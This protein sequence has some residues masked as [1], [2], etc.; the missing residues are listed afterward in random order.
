MKY[1][2]EILQNLLEKIEM[3]KFSKKINFRDHF[4]VFLLIANSGLPFFTNEK[5]ILLASLF[6]TTIFINPALLF[7]NKL[8]NLT[9]IFLLMLLI[10]QWITTGIFDLRTSITLYVRWTYPFIV[11]L[12]VRNRF[13]NIFVNVMYFLTIISLLLFIPSTIS[14]GFENFLLNISKEF[15]QQSSSGFYLYIPNIIIYTIKPE[16]AFADFILFSRNS[17]PFWEP[18]GF[19]SFL[20]VALLFSV[21]I[22]KKFFSKRNMVFIIA[23][24]TTWSTASLAALS[25]LIL[26]YGM[27]ILRKNIYRITLVPMVLLL[28]FNVYTDLPFVQERIDRS[29]TYFENR[30]SIDNQRRDRMISAIVDVRTFSKYP[31]FGTG[32]NKQARYGGTN[33]DFVMMHRNN[34]L[35]DFLVKYG[36]FFFIFYFWQIRK[37]YYSFA[38]QYIEKNRTYANIALLTIAVIGFS[39]ILFQQSVFI[40]LFYFSSFLPKLS[41]NKN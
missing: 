25:V 15:K 37:T 12:A 27:F 13:P 34:G 2:Q 31:V 6:F 21:L 9:L 35:T 7:K 14:S 38:Y 5:L 36:L 33:R 24:I 26:F 16:I 29:I 11:L 1:G 10:G 39:Q 20:I 3:Q 32:R 30:K 4:L 8:F 17:G 18:G 19:G 40:A 22:E 23:L 28:S 41:L